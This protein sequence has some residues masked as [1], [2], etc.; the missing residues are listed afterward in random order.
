ML[1]FAKQNN[2]L[3]VNY[4]KITCGRSLLTFCI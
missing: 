3:N 1:D 4:F 2:D